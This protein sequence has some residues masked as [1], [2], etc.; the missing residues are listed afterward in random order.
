MEGVSAPRASGPFATAPAFARGSGAPIFTHCS[1]FSTCFA[2]SFSFGG[3][4][5][6][7]SDQ[8]RA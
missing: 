6:S 8:R 7:G 1:N 2:D 4:C 3:I 5:R